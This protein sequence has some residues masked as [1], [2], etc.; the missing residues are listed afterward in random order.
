MAHQYS[1]EI[2]QVISKSLLETQKALAQAQGLEKARLQGRE[3]ELAFFRNYL[4]EHFD[5]KHFPYF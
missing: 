1:V 4:S 3:Q 5:L 2:H